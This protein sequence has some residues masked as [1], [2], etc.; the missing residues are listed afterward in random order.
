MRNG[1]TVEVPQ[2]TGWTGLDNPAGAAPKHVT[3]CSNGDFYFYGD[4][5]VLSYRSG[6]SD[7]TP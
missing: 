5:G 6:V 1:I 7:T 2:G 4:N 3:I